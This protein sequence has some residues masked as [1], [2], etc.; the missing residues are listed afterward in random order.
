MKY[1]KILLTGG[2][3]SLGQA[4]IKSGHFKNLA[5]PSSKTLDITDI[6]KIKSFFSNNDFDAVIHCA[7]LA[8]MSECEKRPEK[9]IL[10]NTIGTSTLAMGVL[11]KEKKL[12]KPIRFLFISTDGV[13]PGTKGNYSENNETIPYNKYGWSKLG[14]ESAIRTLSNY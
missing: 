4:I 2:S 8:R 3:G 7:A 6:K 12:N 11:E 10:V 13:Y 9:A 1:N 5:A 14:A